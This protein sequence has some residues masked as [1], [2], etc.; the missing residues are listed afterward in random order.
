MF[1]P[2]QKNDH[3]TEK[4]LPSHR[5]IGPE[6]EIDVSMIKPLRT[7]HRIMTAV[8]AIVVPILFI[9]G[10]WHRDIEPALNE[11]V[12]TS[13]ESQ[14]SR[15]TSVV[16]ETQQLSSDPSLTYRLIA[17][18]SESKRVAV[19]LNASGNQRLPALLVYWTPSLEVESQFPEESVL[20]GHWA[21]TKSGVFELPV[22]AAEEKGSILL[23]SLAQQ[24]MV[25]SSR[26]EF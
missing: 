16:T 20:V 22:R 21:V 13:F 15:F 19:E 6:N 18:T 8:L 1:L 5:G 25:A 26:L 10:I 11:S 23:Y 9:A 14:A 3:H 12:P 24:E 4:L 2:L 17:E 7:R